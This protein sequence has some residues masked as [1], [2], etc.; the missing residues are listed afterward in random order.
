MSTKPAADNGRPKSTEAEN[1]ET[2][3]R[4]LNLLIIEDDE[5]IQETITEYF[6]RT[7]YNVRTADD[8]LMG[9]QAALNDHPDAIVLDLMLPKMDGLAVCRELREKAPYI[10]S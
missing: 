2:V 5:K 8:G 7:G 6:S 4:K 3:D 1:A 9:V 10:R